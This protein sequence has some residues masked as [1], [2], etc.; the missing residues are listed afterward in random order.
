MKTPFLE[1]IL[2]IF[3]FWTS[4]TVMGIPLK[5]LHSTESQVLPAQKRQLSP[6]KSFIIMYFKGKAFFETSSR[7]TNPYEITKATEA[8]TFT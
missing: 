6:T 1:Y 4:A 3:E 5:C 8:T 7:V 2:L